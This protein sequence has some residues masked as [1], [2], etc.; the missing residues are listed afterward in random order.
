MSDIPL[1][2]VVLDGSVLVHPNSIVIL[3]FRHCNSSWIDL[4]SNLNSHSHFIH[5]KMSVKYGMRKAKEIFHDADCFYSVGISLFQKVF[6]A[7]WKLS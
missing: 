3:T 5:F 7:L 2:T 6:W 4:D 1:D